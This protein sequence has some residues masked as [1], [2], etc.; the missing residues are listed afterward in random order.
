MTLQSSGPISLLDI[1]NEFGGS[2]P[3]GINEYYGSGGAPSSG[4][5]S[6]GDFYGRSQFQFTQYV[7]GYSDGG[8]STN[9]YSSYNGNTVTPGLNNSPKTFTVLL[10][11]EA[12]DGDNV[13][14]YYQNG[15]LH[16]VYSIYNDNLA[17]DV[18]FNFGSSSMRFF[19]EITDNNPDT[20]FESWNQIQWNISQGAPSYRALFYH[21]HSY[22]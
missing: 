5:I 21:R 1:Q 3:I 18:T 22:F 2:N 6:I 7:F 13:I 16:T 11:N 9:N 12:N 19:S 8:P 14:S 20:L 4:T 17:L 10:Y 15:S